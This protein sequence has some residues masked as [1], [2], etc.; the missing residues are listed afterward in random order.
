MAFPSDP[1]VGD[2]WTE[3]GREWIYD[4]FGWGSKSL[5]IDM[6]YHLDERELAELTDPATDVNKQIRVIDAPGGE[7]VVYSDGENYRRV[8]DQSPVV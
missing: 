1:N 4:G 2:S 3:F 7:A 5:T 8:S 6:V